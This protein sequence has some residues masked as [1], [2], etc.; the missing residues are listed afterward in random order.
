MKEKYLEAD[1]KSIV[2][3]HM[4]HNDILNQ[5]DTLIN[6]F[7]IGDYSRR[8]DLAVIK[9]NK[10]YAYEIKSASDSLMRLEGQI[11][12]Y[13]MYFDKVTV[14]AAT[15]HIRKVLDIVPLKV[16]VWEIDENGIKV[17]RRGQTKPINDK[18][19]FL[20]LMT[21]SDLIKV[22][23]AEHLNIKDFRRKSLEE[24]LVYLSISKLRKYSIEALKEKYESTNQDFFKLLKINKYL[25]T[26]DLELL[27]VQKVKKY[28][29]M[30]KD[31]LNYF[32]DALKN[33][34]EEIS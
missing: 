30:L 16:A 27:R 34:E 23:R 26:E 7:T 15:K 28:E 20:N 14:V 11:T 4:I 19:S 1:I 5:K 13:L 33:I 8:V 18:L 3:N 17:I 32:L 2:I 6:E 9:A 29:S 12:T 24:N 31:D 10:L 21:V 25:C 22:V